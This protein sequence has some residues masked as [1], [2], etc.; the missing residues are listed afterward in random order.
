MKLDSCVLSGLIT[1]EVRSWMWL[2]GYFAKQVY[3]MTDQTSAKKRTEAQN[4]QNAWAPIPQVAT[5]HQHWHYPTNLTHRHHHR[6]RHQHQHQH[7]H[8][9]QSNSNCNSNS[10]TCSCNTSVSAA[11]SFDIIP[12]MLHMQPQSTYL[13][14]LYLKQY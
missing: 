7:E 14:N 5:Q 11:A 6:H 8:Q 3:P 2:D 9:P 4:P 10:S 12:C 1:T 13:Q